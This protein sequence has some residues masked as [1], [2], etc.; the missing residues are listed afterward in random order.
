MNVFARFQELSL[1]TRV[2]WVDGKTLKVK[3]S[4]LRKPLQMSHVISRETRWHGVQPFFGQLR[5]RRRWKITTNQPSHRG[6]RAVDLKWSFRLWLTPSY[7]M[8]FVFAKLRREII[9][10]LSQVMQRTKKQIEIQSNLGTTIH[11]WAFWLGEFF[12][13]CCCCWLGFL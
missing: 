10:S 4:N 13:G 3:R 1:S 5:R 2:V 7:G 8:L 12:F 9:S 6:L 11:R